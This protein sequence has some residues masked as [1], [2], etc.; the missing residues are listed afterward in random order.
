M[1]KIDQIINYGSKGICQITDIVTK[2]INDNNQTYYVLKPIYDASST[3]YVPQD[4]KDLTAKLCQIISKE[5]I[6]DVLDNMGT[7]FDLWSDNKN[8]REAMYRDILESGNQLEILK[9]IKTIY[10]KRVEK[11]LDNKKLHLFD[12]NIFKEAERR[13]YNEFGYVLNIEPE[14]VLSFIKNYLEDNRSK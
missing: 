1:Y 14:N 12:E 2:Q 9:L 13:L 3:I 10:E 4:N 8:E 5:E 6:F 11:E 7:E